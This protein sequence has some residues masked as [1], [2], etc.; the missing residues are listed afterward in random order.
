MN[1]LVI[2]DANAD[3]SAPLRAFPREGDD[4]ALLGLAWGSGGAGVNVATALALLGGAHPRLLARVGLDPSAELA[5]AAAGRAGVDL[6]FVQRDPALATGLCFAAVSPGGERTFFSYRGA[7][8]ALSLPDP[9]ALGALFDGIGH[10]HVCGH[11]L[12][13]GAQR[14]TTLAL[15]DEAARRALPIS[16]DLCL[17]LCRTAAELV[18]GLA[19][20]LALLTGNEAEIA[21]FAPASPDDVDDE[22]QLH[23]A[24]T[25]LEQTGIPRIIVKLGALGASVIE[26]GTR[27]RVPAFDVEAIDTTAAGDAHVAAVLVSL[28]NGGALD[29]AVIVGKARMPRAALDVLAPNGAVIGHV[30]L[31][32]TS[33]SFDLRERFWL[34][35]DPTPGSVVALVGAVAATAA[36]EGE[37]QV[38]E[39]LLIG[40][41]HFGLYATG[42]IVEG[43]ALALCRVEQGVPAL[44]QALV[45]PGPAAWENP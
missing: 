13:E 44:R 43:A 42:Q 22:T 37:R 17:P 5:L 36:E 38:L 20:K 15:I 39:A 32:N 27:K 18:L 19:P 3:L 41:R 4:A 35:G 7:N 26:Q 12:L 34:V 45:A 14:A 10:L 24:I 29:D 1:V 6:S 30:A 33:G 25:A 16:L 9:D 8:A 2:G 11:A 40:Q 23:A 31:P 28:G 21:L